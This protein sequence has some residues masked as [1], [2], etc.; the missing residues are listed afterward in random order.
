MKETEKMSKE[1]VERKR[2]RRGRERE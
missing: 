2:E 1:E